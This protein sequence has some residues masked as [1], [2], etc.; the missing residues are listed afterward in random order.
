MNRREQKGQLIARSSGSV[1]RINENEYIV[2]SQSNRSNYRIHST[3]LE[4]RCDCP[5]HTY[6]D[7]KCKHIFAVEFS[8][9]LREQVK[10]EI[11]IQPINSVACRF[12]GSENIVKKL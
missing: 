2:N 8:F 3:E 5:D 1:Q 12:C 9:A 6:R 11:V 10:K 4:W 7:V